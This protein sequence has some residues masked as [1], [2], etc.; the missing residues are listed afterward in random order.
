LP[1]AFAHALVGAACASPLPRAARPVGFVV[2]LAVLAAAPDLDVVAF[3]LGIPYEHPL[4]HRGLS[5]SLFFALVVALA[6]LPLCRR[7]LP[8]RGRLGAALVFAAVASHGLLDAFTD[9]GLGVGLFIPF[10]DGR[11]FAPWR[12]ILTS[13]LSVGAFFS[14]RGLAVLANEALWVGV[15]CL[16]VLALARAVRS[17][18]GRSRGAV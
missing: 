17:L 3:R 14:S 5:H 11:Y 10:D 2:A 4:G 9:A 16:A 12:P 1:S 18:S 8:G 7:V 6:S 15:P 13:P